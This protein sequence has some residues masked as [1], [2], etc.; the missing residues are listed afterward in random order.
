MADR[1]TGR[2]LK[3]ESAEVLSNKIDKYFKYADQNKKPYSIAAL[4]V[5]LDCSR[6]T[7]YEYETNPNKQEGFSDIIKKA[8]DKCIAQ[9]EEKLLDGKQNPTGAIF[10]AKNYGYTD[11]QEIESHNINENIDIP[12]EQRPA[13]I[14]G[15]IDKMSEEQRKKFGIE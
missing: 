9:L 3:F 13:I 6:D 14:K 15:Y 10:I 1:K 11:K 2:P 5:Y 12:P 7:I 4:A 8:R